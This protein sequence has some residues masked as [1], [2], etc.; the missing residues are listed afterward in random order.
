MAVDF[1]PYGATTPRI[2]QPQILIGLSP[3]SEGFFLIF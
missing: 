1:V 2:V 3:F